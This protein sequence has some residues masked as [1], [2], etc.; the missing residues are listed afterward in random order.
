MMAMRR[1][2]AT[3]LLA[4]IPALSAIADVIVLHSGEEISG[5]VVMQAGENKS[6]IKLEA[7][8]TRVVPTDQ[9]AKIVTAEAKLEADLAKLAPNLSKQIRRLQAGPVERA[10]GAYELGNMGEQ[11]AAAVP[12]LVA[13][14][15]DDARLQETERGTLRVGDKEY[16]H[17][18]MDKTSPGQV[19][20]MALARI[21]ESGLTA[22]RSA[23]KHP[24]AQAR[25][26]AAEAL[27]L[28]GDKAAVEALLRTLAKDEN[29]LARAS[30]ATALGNIKDKRAI[31]PMLKV[32]TEDGDVDVRT[33]AASA[34]GQFKERGAVRSL[35]E[36]LEDKERRL[37]RT[38][39]VQRPPSPAP[40]IPTPQGVPARMPSP[41]PSVQRGPRGV[42]SPPSMPPV[43]RPPSRPIGK[44]VPGS[45]EGWRLR[46]AAAEA[47]GRI[48]DPLGLPAIV[49]ALKDSDSYVR[50]AAEEGIE[51]FTFC[52]KPDECARD[53][54]TVELLINSMANSS[55]NLRF[56]VATALGRIGD[57]KA[58][59]PLIETLKTEQDQR[60]RQALML[61]LSRITQK[62]FKT[63]DE[64]QAWF[65]NVRD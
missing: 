34:M 42:P 64:W 33:A 44:G 65:R 14:L 2:G 43:A 45:E 23:L 46:C 59:A 31:A 52:A 16:P 56:V 29:S 32:L 10:Y 1:L 40:L 49:G 24:K 9:I 60:F 37:R 6:L 30:A 18:R 51:A 35:V 28:R 47:L 4:G 41:R 8:G 63:A 26:N 12:Y 62:E 7:G 39:L 38:G 36:I 55:A 13:I 19:A 11:A 3:V 54:R 27:G 22:L 15:D 21:G 25:A 61:A 5:R 53:P 20:A 58:I 17:F 48:G 50:S 57:A